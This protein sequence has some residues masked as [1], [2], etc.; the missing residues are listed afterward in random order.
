MRT[1]LAGL[2]ALMLF[3]TP[4]VA[5]V[6][7]DYEDGLVAYRA[8]D[9]EKAFR[10]WKPL[11]EQGEAKAQNN[12]GSMYSFGRGVPEDDAK[13]VYWYRKAAEQGYAKAQFNLGSMY[14]NGEGASK[15]Y[16]KAVYW[17]RKAAKQG[18]TDGQLNLGLKY[19]KGEGV[20]ENKVKA[21]VWWSLAA[22]QGHEKA[23][24]NKGIVKKKMTR[25]QIASPEAIV[26][27]LEKVHRAVSEELANA[28]PP[29]RPDRTH[30][31][32]HAR[33]SGGLGGCSRR[34]QSG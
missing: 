16:A 21:Y 24:R 30:V 8:G 20:P 32:R 22:A 3:A 2:T 13:A 14:A 18:D 29:P 34:L 31:V 15:D 7:G 33:R 4:V 26:R 27:V 19:A 25:E 23:K 1:L 28:H 9:Y 10:L 17:Y 12:L 5:V 11:A 6:A